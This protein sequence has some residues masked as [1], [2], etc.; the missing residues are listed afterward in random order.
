MFA[1]YTTFAVA[2]YGSPVPSEEA[3]GWYGALKRD[4]FDDDDGLPKELMPSMIELPFLWTLATLGIIGAEKT[5]P[6]YRQVK[7]GNSLGLQMAGLSFFFPAV[8]TLRSVRS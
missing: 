8:F 4:G 7:Q 5:V 2:A 3:M 6:E 1:R